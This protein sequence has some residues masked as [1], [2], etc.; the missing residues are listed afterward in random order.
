MKMLLAVMEQTG[1]S[2]VLNLAFLNLLMLPALKWVT[3]QITV[4]DRGQPLKNGKQIFKQAS[5]IIFP[6]QENV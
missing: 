5:T 3:K 4:S 2:N 6:A 1:L